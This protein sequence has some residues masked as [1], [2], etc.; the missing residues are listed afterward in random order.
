M[1][2]NILCLLLTALFIVPLFGSW[3]AAEPV[4]DNFDPSKP[5]YLQGDPSPQ[6]DD[7]EETEEISLGD[8]ATL[9]RLKGSA[10]SFEQF[11]AAMAELDADIAALEAQLAAYE[12][13][14][15]SQGSPGTTADQKKTIKA[16]KDQIQEN[17]KKMSMLIGDPVYLTNGQYYDFQTDISIGFLASTFDITRTY[18]S[19]A[20]SCGI[21]G[22]N[23]ISSLDERIIFGIADV[24]QQDCDDYY[25]QYVLPAE[26]S[27]NA[28]ITAYTSQFE[29]QISEWELILPDIQ[30]AYSDLQLVYS[31]LCTQEQAAEDLE[32]ANSGTQSYSES[33]LVHTEFT[34]MKND[35]ETR[36][37][38]YKN[39]LSI[40][41]DMDACIR[42]A[43]RSLSELR[44]QYQE[45]LSKLSVK[46][47]I[48]SRNAPALISGTKDCCRFTGLA[49]LTLIDGTGGMHAFTATGTDSLQGAVLAST[50]TVWYADNDGVYVSVTK[51][52]EGF[53]ITQRDGC[54]RRYT[55]EGLLL[56]V[57]DGY[58]N[59][60]SFERDSSYRITHIA[61]S[62]G[63]Q[64][65]LTYNGQLLASV[66]QDG[67]AHPLI[68]YGYTDNR[69]SS[70]TDSGGGTLRY[71]WK[72]G[73]L[74]SMVKADGSSISFKYDAI[75][76]EGTRLTTQTTN[77]EGFSEFFEYDFTRNTTL[78]TDHSGVKTLYA[79]DDDYNTIRTEYADGTILS[80][81]YDSN[82]NVLTET[83]N[84]KTTRFYYD[85]MNRKTYVLYP[86]GSSESWTWDDAGNMTS[87]TDRDGIKEIHIFNGCGD[88][89][90][91][92]TGGQT[93]FSRTLNSNGLIETET[94]FSEQ[95][96]ITRFQY[97]SDG[98]VIR[99]LT[100]SKTEEWTW[101]DDGNMTSY[102]LN[103][104]IIS[105][106]QTE[107]NHLTE[108]SFTGL[109]TEYFLNDRKDVVKVL[110]TD[111]FTDET[112][113][114]EYEYDLRHLVTALYKGDGH[115]R[116]LTERL[117]YN[118]EGR[119]LAVIDYHE[120]G[121][122]ILFFDYTDDQGKIVSKPLRA[123][124][125]PLS[126]SDVAQYSL[127]DA[128]GFSTADIRFLVNASSD[129]ICMESA[130][131]GTDSKI[132]LTPAGR[133]SKV[134]SD[135]GG[136]YS[137]MYDQA[138]NES[139]ISDEY[140]NKT[141]ETYYP[142]GTSAGI[143]S[144]KAGEGTFTLD[145][146]YHYDQEGRLNHA[147]TE[148]GCN[149]YF[150]DNTGEI[151]KVIAG[152]RSEEDDAIYFIT[153]DYDDDGRHLTITEG[154]YYQTSYEFNAW[155]EPVAVT[156]GNGN[157]TRYVHDFYGNTI[158]QSDAY[159]NTI[160]YEYDQSGFLTG[161]KYPDGSWQRYAYDVAGNVIEVSDRAGV[162]VSRQ[163]D[164]KGNLIRETGRMLPETDIVR[165]ETG[166]LL[167][168]YENGLLVQSEEYPS[169]TCIIT[170]DAKGF[171]TVYQYDRYGT[172]L[173]ERDRNGI[174]H[175][176]DE[177][178]DGS[179]ETVT[180]MM[181][182]ITEVLDDENHLL[183]LYDKGGRLIKQSNLST[184]NE[185]SFEYD[186]AGNR[187]VM[188]DGERT[189][190]YEYGHIN[191]LLSVTEWE[192]GSVISG[193]S[194]TYD[195][196]GR[197][198]KRSYL[199]GNTQTTSYDEN[200]NIELIVQRDINGSL[201]RGEGYVH[202]SEGR[203]T[204]YIT[205]DLSLKL[206]SYDSRN[207]LSSVQETASST[208]PDTS[209]VYLSADMYYKL[210]S[211]LDR[212]QTTLG[213]SLS[214]LQAMTLTEYSYDANLNRTSMITPYETVHYEYDAEN[215]LIKSGDV[216]LSYDESGNLLSETAPGKTVQYEYSP[217]N[218]IIS[219]HIAD[220]ENGVFKSESYRYDPFGRRISTSG[221]V[222]DPSGTYILEK[223]KTTEYDGFSLEKIK[224]FELIF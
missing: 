37:K 175:Q 97:D 59:W 14:I 86:D 188:S 63:R 159:G 87:H 183:F 205:S 11:L 44:V 61:T 72:D 46:D 136:V 30:T 196:M 199:N 220:S 150:Y 39:S 85:S 127:A 114:T 219:S 147:E 208:S 34:N 184:G 102:S 84:G 190:R 56:S 202:D 51:T 194:F 17:K 212:M 6:D 89:I 213:N 198:T 191:E 22:R 99:A 167:R 206:Y 47:G 182:N 174:S 8:V 13:S 153:Y 94:V 33:C 201:I 217:D 148:K 75:N 128:E 4:P 187:T 171:S 222:A 113:I 111:S 68:Q 54:R 103:G 2:K 115:E 69:I 117:R 166:R 137:Y 119:M 133:T 141:K 71:T 116:I 24:S 100:G 5:P 88:V 139:L 83:E 91:H 216:I 29:R 192:N 142:D 180:D 105:Q 200:G 124:L 164:G 107:E 49:T 36:L 210:Q 53:T 110:E 154:G 81:T 66:S 60:I 160:Q 130:S 93:V 176:Y 96:V 20:E 126:A 179:S 156:D 125:L 168:V 214:I 77:E 70:V 78:H 135:Y 1:K 104:K 224:D 134:T 101:D 65:R 15:G 177:S 42:K 122:V 76:R 62:S 64:Y 95:P 32:A 25:N 169:E 10:A 48:T 146:A 129:C 16:M 209:S 52:A 149:W 120:D 197:E 74:E 204:G 218:R 7:D 121:A 152:D 173:S 163:Y 38:Q 58:G 223:L 161:I 79:F 203:M 90:E 170:T 151:S 50:G 21:T 108:T 207:C 155:G 26:R 215:R 40:S 157:T 123:Y 18:T 221:Y 23:W 43:Q 138:G 98:N 9:N 195:C 162:I 12:R 28:L 57:T 31:E 118:G 55:S 112:R 165:D 143:F 106:Y 172:L 144:Q 185:V 67:K 19:D 211:L 193:L 3:G 80:R 145:A 189:I 41:N 45:L 132:I 82:G 35:A 73:L 109:V 181:G 186:K 178:A 92:I 140:G 131:E 27:L 158:L